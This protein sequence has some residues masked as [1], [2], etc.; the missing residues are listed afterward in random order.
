MAC[1]CNILTC[2][3]YL[4]HKSVVYKGVKVFSVHFIQC[5]YQRYRMLLSFFFLQIFVVSVVGIVLVTA[6]K[7][8]LVFLLRCSCS[9]D[10]VFNKIISE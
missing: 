5:G 7:D 9:S 6:P 1:V 2:I 3:V 10:H 8:V 4:Q